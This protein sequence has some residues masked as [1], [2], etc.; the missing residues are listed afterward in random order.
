M[1]RRWWAAAWRTSVSW[2]VGLLFVIGGITLVTVDAVVGHQAGQLL[3]HGTRVTG[4]V[5][6]VTPGKSSNTDEVRFMDTTVGVVEDDWIDDI[7]TQYGVT[8]QLPVVYKA[9]TPWIAS[10][11]TTAQAQSGRDVVIA[12]VFGVG[13][14]GLGLVML[15]A[16]PTRQVRWVY[17]L[18]RRRRR[19]A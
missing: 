12:A 2:T 1:R 4:T 11:V 3:A 7:P 16:V 19:A 14:A 6:Q 13:F 5:V 17:L 10:A 8:D 9:A 18:A 15:G